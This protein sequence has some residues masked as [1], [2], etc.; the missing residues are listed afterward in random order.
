[1]C[2]HWVNELNCAFGFLCKWNH[3]PRGGIDIDP[4]FPLNNTDKKRRY[5]DRGLSALDMLM[6][7]GGGSDFYDRDR[8]RGGGTSRRPR[9]HG[10]FFFF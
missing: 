2:H 5:Y 1:M 9:V 4:D 8:D 7:R 10:F 3:P 6:A